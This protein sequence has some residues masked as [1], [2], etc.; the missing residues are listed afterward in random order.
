MLLERASSWEGVRG[1][2][3]FHGFREKRVG[4]Y[5]YNDE[6]VPTAL[7]KQSTEVLRL[8]ECV[9]R[10]VRAVDPSYEFSQESPHRDRHDVTYQYAL[11]LGSFE[12]G[13]R[14]MAETGDPGVIVAYDT[15]GRLTRLDGRRVHWVQTYT[16]ER[17]S[18]IVFDVVGPGTPVS[19]E[20]NAQSDSLRYDHSDYEVLE[21]HNTPR[22]HLFDTTSTRLYQEGLWLHALAGG[23]RRPTLTSDAIRQAAATR[24][25]RPSH[26]AAAFHSTSCTRRP[27]RA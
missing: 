19:D 11:S 16:G 1:N 23:D 8:W 17:F 21:I 10:V 18:L 2:P 4:R 7:A 20:T 6:I 15:R 9:G 14:L 22:A 26:A 25:R 3:C 12:G 5:G 13:G 24:T 27:H